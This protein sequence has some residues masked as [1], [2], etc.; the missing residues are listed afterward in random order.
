MT[1]RSANSLR[2]SARLCLRACSLIVHPLLTCTDPTCSTLSETLAT[3]MK[4]ASLST[5]A[6]M[7]PSS[8]SFSVPSSARKVRHT[9][10]EPPNKRHL[11]M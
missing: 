8:Q 4:S 1:R 5:C 11:A 9:G 7:G 3:A 10:A 2:T 6:R